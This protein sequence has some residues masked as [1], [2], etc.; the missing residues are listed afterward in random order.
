MTT[1]S[2]SRS[3]AVASIAVRGFHELNGKY[4]YADYVTGS[5][6]A[7]TYDPATGRAFRNEQVV[8]DSIAVLAFGEDERAKSTT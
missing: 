2:A 3:P 8:P 1:R 4:L 6:W 5:V 7:L